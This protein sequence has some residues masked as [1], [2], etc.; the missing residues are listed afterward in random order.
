MRS[1]RYFRS[2]NLRLKARS[3]DNA[4][5]SKKAEILQKDILLLYMLEHIQAINRIEPWLAQNGGVQNTP[6][7]KIDVPLLRILE[8]GKGN[9][10]GVVVHPDQMIDVLPHDPGKIPVVTSDLQDL[11][12]PLDHLGYEFV[13][14]EGE[15][16]SLGV[17]L[18]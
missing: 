9:G 2:I 8:L 18:P 10:L 1:F 5:G 6:L 17:P 15:G 16:E 14:G 3:T 12:H 7:L 11:I 13:P 4:H